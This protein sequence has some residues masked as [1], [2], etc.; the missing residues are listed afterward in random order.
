MWQVT[1]I[2]LHHLLG[3]LDYDVISNSGQGQCCEM[4]AMVT[5]D[6]KGNIDLLPSSN[7]EREVL[8][9]GVFLLQ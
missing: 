9:V 4:S 8:G 3:S 1:K 7:E 5:Y 2:H 6:I